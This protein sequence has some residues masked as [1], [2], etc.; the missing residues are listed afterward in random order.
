M[1]RTAAWVGRAQAAQA[2]SSPSSKSGRGC[3][4]TASC[5][6]PPWRPPPPAPRGRQVV[7]G[8]VVAC[9]RVSGGRHREG[10]SGACAWQSHRA[11]QCGWPVSYGAAS[12]SLHTFWVK[13]RWLARCWPARHR[14]PS[15]VPP[16]SKLRSA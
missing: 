8:V 2:A 3:R 7:G 13:C 4:P 11:A 6:E 1:T 16:S 5:T 14:P 9:G 15:F 10:G 12:S